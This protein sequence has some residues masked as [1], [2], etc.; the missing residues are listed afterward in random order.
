MEKPKL[1]TQ[2]VKCHEPSEG[3][4]SAGAA[5]PLYHAGDAQACC[6]LRDVGSDSPVAPL[7]VQM[8]DG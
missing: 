8:Q 3:T 6:H 7:W 1:A 2:L 5:A 4:L